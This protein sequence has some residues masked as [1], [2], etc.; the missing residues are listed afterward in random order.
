MLY[1]KWEGKGEENDRFRLGDV[2]RRVKRG[3]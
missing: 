2:K 3:R 1:K